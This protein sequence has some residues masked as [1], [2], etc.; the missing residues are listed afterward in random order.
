MNPIDNEF[1]AFC[2]QATDFQLENILKF[3]WDAF[4]HRDYKSAEKAAI[5]RGW[6]VEKGK[7]CV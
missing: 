2:R 6:I 3:E 7:R 4:K 5:E 1:V